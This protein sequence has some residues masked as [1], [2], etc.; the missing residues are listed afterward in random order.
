MRDWP[1]VPPTPG[2][3]DIHLAAHLFRP[4]RLTLARELRGLT[5]TELAE[6]IQKSPGAISQFES[7]RTKPEPSTVGA[8]ALTLQFPAGFFARS[9]GRE[10]IATD[11]A[12]FRSLRSTS[13]SRR[14]QLLARAVLVCELVDVLEEEVEFPAPHVPQATAAPR[15][16]DDVEGLAEAVRHEWGLGLG[17]I[18]NLVALLE[19]NGIL[20]LRLP[21]QDLAVDAFSVRSRQ[22]P[23]VF[24]VTAKGSTSRSRI[25][26]AHELGHLVMHHDVAPGNAAMERE[27]N[28][29]ASAFLFPREH[30]LSE[31]PRG[32]NWGLM[33]E[34]KQRWG[35][36]VAAIVRRAFDLGMISEATYRRGF[37]HLNQTGQRK[38]EEF[39]PPI[40]EATV[41]RDAIRLVCEERPDHTLATE[42]GV[43]SLDDIVG[44]GLESDT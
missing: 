35:V 13:Q 6:R 3:N 1:S 39:E 40:E 4:E 16:V 25:D 24:L 41:L 19:S 5:K 21:E 32:L 34:L 20:V 29:F 36:S 22:R 33:Y 9:G 11:A 14:R 15:T 31:G 7:G 42:M 12:Y 37:M 23:L 30:F 28:R 38:R 27:A 44:G 26:G 2:S 18:S 43:H 17:P 10:P 8:L